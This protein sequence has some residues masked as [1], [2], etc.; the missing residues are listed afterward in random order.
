[1]NAASVA[2]L[3]LAPPAPV[4]TNQRGQVTLG[5]QPSGYDANLRWVAAPGATSYRLYWREAWAPDWQQTQ[6]V[7]DVTEFVLKGLSIDNLAFG[8]AAVGPDGHE[9]LVRSYVP[10]PRRDPAVKLVPP[11]PAPPKTAPTPAPSSK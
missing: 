2:S 8:V 10:P 3:A 7:G 5:R 4:V 6:L 1:V 11:K 9:S